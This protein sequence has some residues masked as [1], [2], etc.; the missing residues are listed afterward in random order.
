MALLLPRLFSLPALLRPVLGFGAPAW[1]LR[2]LPSLWEEIF[3]AILRAVPK[4]KVS[5]SRKS[6]RASN[7]GLKD[8]QNIVT[9]SA[10]GTAKL[11]HNICPHCY[12]SIRRMWK[13]LTQKTQA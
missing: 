13:S 10:C 11:A 3:P 12:S 4:S 1:N 5:H 2:A 7:K 9:C 8:K 6:N